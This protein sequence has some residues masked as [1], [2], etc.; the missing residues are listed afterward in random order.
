MCCIYTEMNHD[1]MATGLR[2][3]MECP[4]RTQMVER[5]RDSVKYNPKVWGGKA[6]ITEN[7]VGQDEDRD[8]YKVGLVVTSWE[9]IR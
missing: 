9:V 2:E 8:L 1:V 6:E 4:Y 7:Q 3:Q 5:E